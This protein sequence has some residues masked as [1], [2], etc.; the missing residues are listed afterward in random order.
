MKLRVFMLVVIGIVVCSMVAGAIWLLTLPLPRSHPSSPG[1]DAREYETAMASLAPSK[2]QRPLIAVIGINDAT[3]TTDYLVPYGILKRAGIADVMALSMKD[4]PV[5]LYPALTVRADATAAQFDR[6][7]PTG[8]DYVIVPAM[9]RDDDP[10]VIAWLRHQKAKGA[11]IIGVCAGAKVVAEAGL[12]DGRRATTHWYYLNTLLERHPDIEYVA[13]RRWVVDNGIVTTTGITASI[14]T[15]LTLIEAIADSETAQRV[16]QDLGVTQ[17]S[18][19]HDS[20]S[21]RFTRPFAFA[22]MENTLAFWRREQL[23]LPL[24]TGIDEVSLALVADAWSRTYRSRVTSFTP[25][26]GTIVTRNGMQIIADRAAA[27][28]DND[29]AVPVVDMAHP[30]AALTG[31]LNAIGKRYGLPTAS[32]VAMQLEYPWPPAGPDHN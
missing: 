19:A 6:R 30:A 22:V 21:F 24:H 18:A 3:E 7:Y 5:R 26:H 28:S 20:Q 8:A 25:D 10:A 9:S 4:A 12:L 15:M 29:T 31:T 11:I 1:L 23:A 14:P 17:W 32:V 2:R 13:N 27:T 16:A